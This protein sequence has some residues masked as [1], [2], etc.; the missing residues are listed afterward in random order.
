M[1]VKNIQARAY[2]DTHTVLQFCPQNR[3]QNCPQNRPQ[4]LPQHCFQNHTKITKF[5][6]ILRASRTRNKDFR[7]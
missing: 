4:N 3:P 2:N 5:K 6:L 1:G 7:I